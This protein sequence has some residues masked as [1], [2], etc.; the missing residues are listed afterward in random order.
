VGERSEY[1]CQWRVCSMS[2]FV[3]PITVA[4]HVMSSHLQQDQRFREI[5]LLCAIY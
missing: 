3:K 2:L 1:S 5:A 4:R